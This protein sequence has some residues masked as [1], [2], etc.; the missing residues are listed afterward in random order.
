MQLKLDRLT[1]QYGSKIALD[2]LDATFKPGIYGLL[3]ANGA[4]KTTMMRMICGILKPTSGEVTLNDRNIREMGENYRAVLGYLPQEFGY[5][6]HFTAR[7]FLLYMASSKGLNTRY[8]KKK[9]HRTFRNIQSL[10]G[11]R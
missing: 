4:G 3:G 10:R 8:A 5:Y 9:I 1:K 7:D 11:E 6:P 2:R